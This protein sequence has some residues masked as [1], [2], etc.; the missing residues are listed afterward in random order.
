M[1]GPLLQPARVGFTLP[2]VIAMMDAA[3]HQAR[4]TQF[5]M[6]RWKIGHGDS[7]IFKT[8]L[9][10]ERL[11]D[12]PEGVGNPAVRIAAIEAARGSIK[13]L[14]EIDSVLAWTKRN[15][16]FRG[17]NA[18]T[19]QSPVVTL[20][21]RAGDCDD[22]SVL[23][24]ALLRSLGYR[25]MFKTVATQ[26]I[27]PRQF[28]HVYVVVQ[29]KRT[30]R[31]VGLDSTVP[32]SFA[33]WEPPMIYRQRTFGRLGDAP[34]QDT[35][36]YQPLVPAPPAPAGLSPKAQFAYN[37]TAPIVQALSSQIAHGTTPAATVTGNINLGGGGGLPTWVWLLFGAG[38]LWLIFGRRSGD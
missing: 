31:W 8:I 28:S 1:A 16:E 30:G 35:T 9:H 21:L 11:V 36:T 3:E 13:N 38:T 22:H 6:R 29:E 14:T 26:R 37:L 25:T 12:G 5:T 34:Y 7:A 2:R 10:M 23:M 33:G 27:A 18:E 4:G 17:E 24:A 32:G 20:Q 19:L 15:I